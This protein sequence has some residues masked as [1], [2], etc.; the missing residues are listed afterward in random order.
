MDGLA[1]QVNVFISYLMETTT[2][3]RFTDF[4]RARLFIFLSHFLEVSTPNKKEYRK[5]F[6]GFE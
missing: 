5:P 4:L 6:A 3:E 2:T 1:F